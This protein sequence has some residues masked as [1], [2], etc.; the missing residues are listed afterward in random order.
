VSEEMPR[1]D[2]NAAGGT[3]ARFFARDATSMRVTCDGCGATSFLGTLLLYGGRM[4]MILRCP[5]CAAVNLRAAEINGALRVDTKGTRCLIVKSSSA[6]P[7]W[8]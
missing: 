4:G 7:D 8:A 2:G 3:L 6:P 5:K 1:L